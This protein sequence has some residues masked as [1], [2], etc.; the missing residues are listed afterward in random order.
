MPLHALVVNT[1]RCFCCL[2]DRHKCEDC[3]S[4]Y[5]CRVASCG[6]KHH[7]HTQMEA[8]EGKVASPFWRGYPLLLH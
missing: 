3:P 1:M 7:T 6:G 5:R 2:S 4:E 8:C